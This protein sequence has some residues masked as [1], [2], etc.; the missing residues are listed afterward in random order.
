MWTWGFF[1]KYSDFIALC[2]IKKKKTPWILWVF[3]Y[4]VD[5]YKKKKKQNPHITVSLFLF[6]FFLKGEFKVQG[7]F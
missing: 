1:P 5:E 2:E 4:L 6:F 3:S 7:A